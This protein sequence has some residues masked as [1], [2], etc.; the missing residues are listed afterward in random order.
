MRNDELFTY[1][2]DRN[3]AISNQKESHMKVHQENHVPVVAVTSVNSSERRRR[4]LCQI[5][6]YRSQK[7]LF[8]NHLRWNQP[9]KTQNQK[10]LLHKER[11]EE[12]VAEEEEEEEDGDT[13]N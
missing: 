1:L 10:L 11:M 3:A 9:C 5:G 12:A 7:A 13:T 6:Y 4:P 2:E 8:K